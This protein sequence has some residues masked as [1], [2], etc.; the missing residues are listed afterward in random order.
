MGRFISMTAMI[1]IHGHVVGLCWL[2]WFGS[3][4]RWKKKKG[5]LQINQSLALMAYP[6]YQVLYHFFLAGRPPCYL[7]LYMP[8]YVGPLY[9]W[10][11]ARSLKLN[12]HFSIQKRASIRRI[13]YKFWHDGFE[14]RN[15]KIAERFLYMYVHM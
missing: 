12:T 3:S 4:L 2:R 13:S 5:I 9:E 15:A 1:I 14:R 8:S 7:A 6:I 11:A 10:A